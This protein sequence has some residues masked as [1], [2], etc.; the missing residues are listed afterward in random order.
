MP[1]QGVCGRV[2]DG[3]NMTSVL[4][5]LAVQRRRHSP[6]STS[7]LACCTVGDDVT[8]AAH[9]L[10]KRSTTSRIRVARLL[11]F[12][13]GFSTKGCSLESADQIAGHSLSHSRLALSS[14][15]LVSHSLSYSLFSCALAATL[16]STLLDD[17]PLSITFLPPCGTLACVQS[18][19]GGRLL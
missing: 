4:Y 14:R 13:C 17:A 3:K 1:H 19:R 15:T 16:E 10:T 7:G 18:M 5:I 11:A 2:R 6:A 12:S 8:S 9:D